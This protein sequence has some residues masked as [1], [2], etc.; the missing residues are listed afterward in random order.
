MSNIVVE[1]VPED[2]NGLTHIRQ[3]RPD[4]IT[5]VEDATGKITA[6]G[7]STA[8][9]DDQFAPDDGQT[10]FILSYLPIG[11][12]RMYVNGLLQRP[13]LDFVIVGRVATWLDNG[14]QLGPDDNVL[15]LYQRV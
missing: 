3:L 8:P 6:T 7:E 14:Y 9:Q 11:V 13:G 1:N 15:F 10:V 2:G 4:G 12:V 5:I